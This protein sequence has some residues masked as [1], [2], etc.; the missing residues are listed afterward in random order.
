MSQQEKNEINLVLGRKKLV[1][2][3][4]YV[5]EENRQSIHN[6]SVINYQTLEK[7]VSLKRHG[8]I[9]YSK[10]TTLTFRE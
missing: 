1:L 2:F 7:D 9:L 5:G 8:N 6:K 10:D 3:Y 4:R